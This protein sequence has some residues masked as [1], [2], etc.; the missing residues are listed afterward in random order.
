[1]QPPP[2]TKLQRHE[3]NF[4]ATFNDLFFEYTKKKVAVFDVKFEEKGEEWRF[5]L[6]KQDKRLAQMPF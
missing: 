4:I 5:G 6:S 1:M 3:E 2:L